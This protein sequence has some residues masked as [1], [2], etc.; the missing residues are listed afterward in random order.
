MKIK[1][2]MNCVYNEYEVKIK[3]V[4]IVYFFLAKLKKDWQKVIFKVS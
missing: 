1:I 3:M 2:S 4:R